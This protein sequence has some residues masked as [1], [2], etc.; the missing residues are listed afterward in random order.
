MYVGFGESDGSYS[1]GQNL[2]FTSVISLQNLTTNIVFADQLSDLRITGTGISMLS[3]TYPYCILSAS[4]YNITLKA[5]VNQTELL[6][7]F[8]SALS[9]SGNSQN[10]T[11]FVSVYS[12]P[13]NGGSA[14]P[15]T[16]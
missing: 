3:N 1:S 7:V 16:Q 9:L 13:F 12:D 2:T 8:D 10:E 11:F 4:E 6:C 5:E 14:L 15:Q